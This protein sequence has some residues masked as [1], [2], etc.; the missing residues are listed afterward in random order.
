MEYRNCV[1]V[2]Y[3]NDNDNDDVIMIVARTKTRNF[4]FDFFLREQRVAGAMV[5]H[6][7]SNWDTV[8][9]RMDVN[10]GGQSNTVFPWCWRAFFFDPFRQVSIHDFT[11]RPL[12][13]GS[14]SSSTRNHSSVPFIY[15]RPATPSTPHPVTINPD[16][17]SK[18]SPLIC[19]PST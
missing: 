19:E 11:C 12:S 3:N 17:S 15:A 1:I 4:K 5:Q 2:V 18:N 8:A 7:G 14:L 13:H 6:N 10:T 16:T 9:S